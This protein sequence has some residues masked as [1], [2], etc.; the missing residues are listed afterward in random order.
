VQSAVRGDQK[1]TAAI[2]Q[3]NAALREA[4]F[5]NAEEASE[6]IKAGLAL[7]SGRDLQILAALTCTRLGDAVKAQAISAGLQKQFP[8]NSLLNHYW[9]PT[10]RA[11]LEVRH[12]SA[13]QA[14][15][16]LEDTAPY[17][18]GFPQ[19][20]FE[21]GGLLYPVYVRGQAY[22]ALRRG[23][24]AAHEFQRILDHHYIPVN[25][26]LASL[27]RFRHAQALALTDD[28]AAARTAYQDFL[29]LWKDADPDIP[30]LK[31]AKAEYAKLR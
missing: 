16:I 9:L 31:Q 13:A 28:H 1:E 10:I 26:P 15:V 25:A 2:W 17:E 23:T 3:L 20:Q 27:A 14:L 7:A 21:E 5:G 11:S 30:I 29:A 12:G 22:L 18:L 19:P 24:E 8:S 6:G 4:E